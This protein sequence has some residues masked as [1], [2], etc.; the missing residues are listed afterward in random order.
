MNRKPYH[1]GAELRAASAAELA[2]Q[3]GVLGTHFWRIARGLD[4]RPVQPGRPHQSVGTEETYSDDLPGLAAVQSRLPVL[5]EGVA[6]RLASEG[7]WARTVVLKLKFA[8]RRVVTRRMTLP[9]PVQDAAALAQTAARLL[10]P[11][12]VQGQGGAG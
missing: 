3:F 9:A 4:D 6:R 2:T 7:L 12:L 11:E 10:T 5:A 8:D 1:T